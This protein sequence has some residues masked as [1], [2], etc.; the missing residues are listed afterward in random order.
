MAS[1]AYVA[2]LRSVNVA[3]HGTVAMADL[4]AAFH[5]AG[6]PDATTYIQSGNVVFTGPARLAAATVERAV[7]AALGAG[8][9]VVLRTARQL[10]AVVDGN[11]FAGAEPARIHVAFFPRAV[12]AAAVRALDAARFAPEEAAFAG[13][14]CYLHLPDGMGRAKLPAWLARRLDLPFTA[15]NWNT[16]T[17]LAGL[18][19][20]ATRTA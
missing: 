12:P 1:T 5:A 7:G 14:D 13:A 19:R 2:L 4:R 16:V 6:Y 18:A 3:G 9:T 11:P 17:R 15:R 8:V 20:A 10:Q